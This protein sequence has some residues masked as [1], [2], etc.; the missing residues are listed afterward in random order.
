MSVYK[1]NRDYLNYHS[2]TMKGAEL[3]SKMPDY[4]PRFLATPRL[5]SWM[6]PDASFYKSENCEATRVRIPD[7]TIWCAGVL[8]LNAKAFLALNAYLADLGE[9]LPVSCQ[10]KT[11]HLFNVLNV[12]EDAAIDTQNTQAHFE[13]G[14]FFGLERLAF[15]EDKLGDQILF[16]THADKL[17]SSYCTEAFKQRIESLGLEGL[18]FESNL[19]AL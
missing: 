2:F 18:I 19:T 5:D 9:F 11:Y 7:I 15:H 1:V 17:V 3:Y 8:A 16:K 6:K 4:S 10:G 13:N 14:I 12:I